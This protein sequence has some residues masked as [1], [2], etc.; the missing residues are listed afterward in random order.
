MSDALAVHHGSFGRAVIYRIDRPMVV[1]AH[2]EGHLL[3]HLDGPPAVVPVEHRPRPVGPAQ[4]VA[5]SPWQPHAFQPQAPGVATLLLILYIRPG[6]FL[7]AS[8]RASSSLAFGR[9]TIEVTQPMRRLGL[10]VAHGMLEDIVDDLALEAAVATLTQTAFD[11]SWQWTTGGMGFGAR[12]LPAWDYR[13]RN[14]M[15]LMAERLGD[16]AGLDRIARD[17]GLSRPHFYKLF[18]QQVGVTP[19]LYLNTLRMERAID[20]LTAGRDPVTE[21]GLDLGFSSQASFS[22][23]F[24][25]NVG[26]APSD[27][28]RSVHLA[29]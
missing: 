25:A 4:A 2:R 19:N 5:V 6:W 10:R 18:R 20:R 21:I 13:I 14:S 23:F 29:G 11:Q 17:A 22:R 12:R 7:E 8:R 1:H 16:G 27:Y 15:R 3:F 28:R 26:I 9:A 24:T